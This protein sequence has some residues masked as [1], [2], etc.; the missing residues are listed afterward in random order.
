NLGLGISF[1]VGSSNNGCGAKQLSNQSKLNPQDPYYK[2][3]STNILN[4]STANPNPCTGNPPY[5]QE[6][7]HGNSSSITPKSNQLP[8]GSAGGG[9]TLTLSPGNNFYCGDQML[10][11][12]VTVSTPNGAAVMIIE[13]GSLDLNGFTFGMASQNDALTIVFTGSNCCGYTHAPAD[14]TNGPGGALDITPPTTGPWAGMA[15]V[16]DPNLTTGV[17][18]ASAGNSPTWTITGLIYT[19]H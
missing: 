19:P 12:N 8:N 1:T 14:N 9:G 2:Q 16:Q 6:T 7:H 4:F 3:I 15:I 18:V 13:N 5:P 10:T 17:D 11:G